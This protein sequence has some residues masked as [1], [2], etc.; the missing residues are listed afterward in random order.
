M[1]RPANPRRS[2]QKE[3]ALQ[4]ESRESENSLDIMRTVH[5][6]C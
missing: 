3:L 1:T 2:K 5:E 4:M 6:Y